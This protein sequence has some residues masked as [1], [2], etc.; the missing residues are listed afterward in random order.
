MSWYSEPSN[1]TWSLLNVASIQLSQQLFNQT[2][3]IQLLVP[4][5]I[6]LNKVRTVCVRTSMQKVLVKENLFQ[7]SLFNQ[8][9][10]FKSIFICRYLLFWCFS[11]L[12]W[13]MMSLPRKKKEM[14]N[15]D[16]ESKEGAREATNEED[17]WKVMAVRP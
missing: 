3:Q 13:L 6:T 7:M 17:I 11:S 15:R 9:L 1:I 14:Q 8:F 2:W 4:L 10:W 5:L 12:S 16:T